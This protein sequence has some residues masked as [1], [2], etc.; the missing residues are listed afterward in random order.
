MGN[1]N[2]KTENMEMFHHNEG[3][4]SRTSGYQGYLILAMIAG[5]FIVALA[6]LVQRM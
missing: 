3:E 1:P 5:V 2:A 6:E 4:R